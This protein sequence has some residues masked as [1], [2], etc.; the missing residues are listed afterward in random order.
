MVLGSNGP[1][2]AYDDIQSSMMTG[3]VRW[4]KFLHSKPPGKLEVHTWAWARH[5]IMLNPYNTSFCLDTMIDFKFRDNSLQATNKKKH[6]S[7]WFATAKKPWNHFVGL[8]DVVF[9]TIS[10]WVYQCP[11]RRED[12]DMYPTGA[13]NAPSSRKGIHFAFQDHMNIE[14]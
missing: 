3:V 2:T 12:V 13:Y 5:E 9:S 11:A 14:P 7:I 8:V 4:R 1:A 6:K 10:I